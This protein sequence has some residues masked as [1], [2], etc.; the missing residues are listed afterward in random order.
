MLPSIF[1]LH[2]RSYWTLHST[3]D[4]RFGASQL[5]RWA[6]VAHRNLP[7]STSS[8][9]SL[10]V[11]STHSYTCKIHL[12]SVSHTHCAS[13]PPTLGP[14]CP[15]HQMLLPSF[16]HVDNHLLHEAILKPPQLLS[17][18][19]IMALNH[20]LP[21]VG[22]FDTHFIITECVWLNPSTDLDS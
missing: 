22:D 5:C 11:L 2:Y 3:H 9:S 16:P 19:Y 17:S 4:G 18:I 6:F 12:L 14:C 7:C 20:C 1:K 8:V 15:L 21:L 13:P 10:S